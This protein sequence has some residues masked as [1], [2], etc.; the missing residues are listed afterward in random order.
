MMIMPSGPRQLWADSWPGPGVTG[1]A[2]SRAA[3]VTVLIIESQC[4]P[5]KSLALSVTG[6]SGGPAAAT[7][8]ARTGVIMMLTND[9]SDGPAAACM[10][11]I[12]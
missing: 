6:P 11:G 8:T 12:D 9:A 7:V 4:R 2:G 3:T 10:Q 5:V 1:S